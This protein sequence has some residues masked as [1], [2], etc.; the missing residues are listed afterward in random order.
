MGDKS[1]NGREK[2]VG[3]HWEHEVGKKKQNEGW[4]LNQLQVREG[5]TSRN[6][7]GDPSISS[8]LKGKKDGDEYI[9][10]LLKA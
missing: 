7:K 8:H 3:A 5:R 9:N 4:E 1:K 6:K 2:R 10:L